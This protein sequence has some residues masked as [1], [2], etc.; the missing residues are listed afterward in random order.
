MILLD[1]FQ[2]K[3]IQMN[4]ILEHFIQPFLIYLQHN[5]NGALN[6]DHS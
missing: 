6:M 1:E 3:C 2:K 4:S 5:G